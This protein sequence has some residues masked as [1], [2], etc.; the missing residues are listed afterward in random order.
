M[1][2][3]QNTFLFRA[4]KQ[5]K[6]I[7]CFI[8]LFIFFQQYFYSKKNSSFP[9]Y[10]WIMYSYPNYEPDTLTQLEI[11]IDN[12]RLNLAKIPIWQEAVLVNTFKKYYELQQTN[13]HEPLKQLV[14]ERSNEIKIFSKNYMEQAICN[15]KKEAEKYKNWIL[16]YMEKYVVHKKI[17][18]IDYKEVSYK[19]AQTQFTKAGNPRL[20]LT[21][22]YVH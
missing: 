9:W 15:Q 12:E 6:W 13:Y 21:I 10:V 18:R 5:N 22:K 2:Y 17:H 14:E 19:Q 3:L 16:T 1:K 20:L 7:G 11:Y 8:L 4:F